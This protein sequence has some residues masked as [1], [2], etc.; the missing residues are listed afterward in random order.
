M[1]LKAKIASLVVDLSANSASFNAELKKSKK[2]T[3]AWAEEV[4]NKA[5]IGGLALA[6]AATAATAG[7][8]ALARQRMVDIDSM[9]KHADKIGIS[10]Q[11]LAGL[12]H[13]AELNGVAQ[14]NLD[15]GLQ[16]MVRR[17]AEAAN[18][19]GEA[20]SALAELRLN[21]QAMK[22]MSP[23]QQFAAIA[24]RMKDIDSQSDRVRI[25][26]KL[27]DSEGV[28]L[29]NTM[30]DGAAGISAATAEAE[31]LGLAVSR[32][33]AAKIEA[34]NDA[35]YRASQ[36]WTGLGNTIAV[37]VSPYI[38]AMKTE[39]FNSAVEANG[40]R[41]VVDKAMSFTVKAI[42]YVGNAIRGMQLLWK[43]A[44]L[45]VAT[46]VA[47]SLQNLESL[48][49]AAI[50]V[51]NLLPFVDV[52]LD[53]NSG[54][55]LMADV[56]RAR[57][58]ELK[59]EMHAVAMQELPSEKIE[60]WSNDVVE[61]ATAAAKAVAKVA[62]ST[63]AGSQQVTD[64][65][66][67]TATAN[68]AERVSS[69][70]TRGTEHYL[71]AYERRQQIINNALA[72]K[73]ISEERH[74]EISKQNWSRYQSDIADEAANNQKMMVDSS[75]GFFAD[76][77]TLSD[78]GNKK[79]AAIGRAAARINVAISTIEAAQ[80]AYT[81]AAKWGGIP[82]GVAAAAAATIAG[83][84]RL[85]AINT[86]GSGSG[87]AG[88]GG[89]SGGTTFDQ[90]LPNAAATV[91]DIPGGASRRDSG[92]VVIQGDYYAQGAVQAMDSESF[93]EFAQRNRSA[94]ANATESELNEYGRSLVA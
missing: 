54:I 85:R 24:E 63:Q 83:L 27:F 48:A 30:R 2:E 58:A 12:R 55:A 72:A 13:Q 36:A 19:T 23:D 17:V 8:T 10:T 14:N 50:N 64:D 6:A 80:N 40:F 38:A 32:V 94:I 35:G 41:D 77:A 61:K 34:A 43:G 87:S 73:Q 5:K 21:A 44:Q 31:A 28:G 86:A 70:L 84:M 52:K 82:A 68:D 11:A 65:Q 29:V 53:P 47:T 26:F 37:K 59:D 89:M 66:K 74:F 67:P 1:S 78:S 49:Q 15:M 60:K 88:S 16:R 76:L 20:V 25:A 71:E 42:G 91:S 4:K 7:L 92:R 18:G 62:E 90:N 56:A 69:E 33:D 3:S 79:L 81:W 45:L 46:F 57:V 51:T 22:Q 75:K 93:A 9:T 39:F